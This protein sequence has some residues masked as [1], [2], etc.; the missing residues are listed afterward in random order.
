MDHHFEGYVFF[1][2]K[3]LALS[4]VSIALPA[5]TQT[6][7]PWPPGYFDLLLNTAKA[8]GPQLLARKPPV[9][10]LKTELKLSEPKNVIQSLLA[11][12]RTASYLLKSVPWCGLREDFF[13]LNKGF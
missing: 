11:L 10:P 3:E 8:L 2:W 9:W 13:A 6:T 12:K 4:F 7:G 1:V 5:A